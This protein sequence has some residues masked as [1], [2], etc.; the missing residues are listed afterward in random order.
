MPERNARDRLLDAAIR[1]FR[2]KGYDATSVDDL[3]RAAGVTKGAFFHHFPSKEA[4]ALAAIE[5]FLAWLDGIFDRAGWRRLPDP[6]D[7]VLAYIDTRTRLLNGELAH[8]TCLL[9]ALAQETFATHPALR[10][11]CNAG[12]RSHL[13]AFEADI[14]EILAARGEAGFTAESL[15]R[16][17]MA[18]IQGAFV[19]AKAH[20]GAAPAIDSLRHLRRYVADLLDDRPTIG[21][22][23]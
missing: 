1:Q 20:G 10:E 9:G 11:A 12:F 18:V 23:A 15:S 4:I 13:A 17:V 6:R 19:L 14:A 3:C 21:D 2:V 16:H 5:R 7:R 22:A 8:I